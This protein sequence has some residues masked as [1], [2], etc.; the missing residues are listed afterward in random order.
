MSFQQTLVKLL[1]KSQYFF[2][3]NLKKKDDNKIEHLQCLSLM[4][5]RTDILAAILDKINAAGFLKL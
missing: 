2:A 3:Q 5:L 1:V 4:L